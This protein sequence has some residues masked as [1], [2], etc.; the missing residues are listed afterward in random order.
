M[1]ENGDKFNYGDK[2]HSDR[3]Q[4]R[5][6]GRRAGL[7]FEGGGGVPPWGTAAL[8]TG[9]VKGKARRA[10]CARRGVGD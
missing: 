2:L 7:G 9:G 1:G 3:F 8:D 6:V 5:G 4:G 10:T